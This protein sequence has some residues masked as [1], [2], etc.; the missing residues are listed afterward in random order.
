MIGPMHDYMIGNIRSECQD[1]V[2]VDDRVCAFHAS[3]D[4]MP[5]FHFVDSRLKEY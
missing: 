4:I 5:E 3:E 2:A 1:P